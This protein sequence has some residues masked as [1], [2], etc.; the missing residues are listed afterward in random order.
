MQRAKTDQ[1]LRAGI[2]AL[3]G[4]LVF[5]IYDSI[6][7]KIVQIGDTAPEFTITTD[8]GRTVS[9]DNFGG[10]LLVLNFWATWC[11][12]CVQEMPSLEQFSRDLSKEGV[13]VLGISVDKDPNAYR[14]FLER[15]NV[16]F[17]TARDP[18]HKI[19]ADYGTFQYP[20]TYVINTQ[21]RVV[22]KFIGAEMW[23]DPRITQMIRSYL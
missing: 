3:L 16:S 19:N 6:H 1:I 14:S 11:P 13:V 9:R 21:G 17:L 18:E 5:V 8:I 7:E 20:E 2:V 4:L 15:A 23:T 22:Q 10:K 12:P